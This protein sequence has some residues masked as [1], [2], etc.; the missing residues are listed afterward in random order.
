M[1]YQYDAIVERWVDGDTVDVSVDLGFKCYT[2]QRLRLNGIDTPERGQTGFGEATAFAESHCPVGS[3]IRVD[4]HKGTGK[5]GRYLADI[6]TPD[7][8][9]LIPMM[10][11]AGHGTP[12]DGGRR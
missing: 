10:L 6:Q 7:G 1:Q 5:F 3:T 12:Y 8:N 11:E 2:R 4:T 9:A